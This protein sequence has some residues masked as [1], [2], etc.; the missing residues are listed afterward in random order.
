MASVHALCHLRP[1]N[2]EDNLSNFLPPHTGG[3]FFGL[4][5]TRRSRL[6]A[7]SVKTEASCVTMVSPSRSMY[8]DGDVCSRAAET[9]PV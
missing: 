2:T 3:R 4:V 6:Q 1:Y 7:R 5:R 8:V 9:R